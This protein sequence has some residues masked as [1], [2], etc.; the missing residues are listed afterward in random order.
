L[1]RSILLI[2]SAILFLAIGAFL[3]ADE[4]RVLLGESGM[5]NDHEVLLGVRRG[6]TVEEAERSLTER[7]FVRNNVAEI[8]R[9]VDTSCAGRSRAEA[10]EFRTYSQNTWWG[11]RGHVC[12]AANDGRVVA[13]RAGFTVIQLP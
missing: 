8:F 7:R 5:L 12:L 13:M 6:I 11:R 1:M 9:N 10:P 4:N 3:I 2:V